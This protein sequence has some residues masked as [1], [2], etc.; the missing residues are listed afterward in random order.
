MGRYVKHCEQTYRNF[1]NK[2]IG[3]FVRVNI[4]IATTLFK[5]RTPSSD[6]N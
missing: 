6:S 2:H 3:W 5:K 1:M 4:Y